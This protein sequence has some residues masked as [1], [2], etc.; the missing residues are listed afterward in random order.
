MCSGIRQ[1]RYCAGCGCPIDKD[2]WCTSEVAENRREAWERC[3]DNPTVTLLAK[4]IND[5]PPCVGKGCDSIPLDLPE[6]I[7]VYKVSCPDIS[8]NFCAFK[9]LLDALQEVATTLT[10]AEECVTIQ[11]GE[12][13]EEEYSN[14]PEFDGY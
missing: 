8:Q 1:L 6:K 13:T 12:M 7:K 14:L 5:P 11:V 2:G 3:P 9:D 10:E 4:C